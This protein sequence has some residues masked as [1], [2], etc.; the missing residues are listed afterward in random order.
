MSLKLDRNILQWFDSFF[1]DSEPE[2]HNDN[3]LCN[4]YKNKSGGN[5]KTAFTLEK[6]NSSYWKIYFEIPQE[7]IIKLRK[8]VHPIF[9]EYIYEQISFYNDNRIYNFINSNL[10]N[11]FNNVAFYS[12][13][14]GI[15]AYTINFRK[16][17]IDKCSYLAIGE[18]RQID[19]DLYLNVQS[20]ELFNFFNKDKSFMMNL[21]FSSSKG[22]NLLDSLIDLRKSIIINDRM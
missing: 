6:E 16:G 12:Y 7:T 20:Q 13:D 19:E 8:N 5:E 10:L 21:A 3:F 2:V 15:N 17:F 14:S 4:I 11:V 1:E 9:R 22:E 18:D